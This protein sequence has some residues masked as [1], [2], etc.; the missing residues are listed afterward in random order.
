M[1]GAYLGPKFDSEAIRNY[2]DENDLPYKQ[3]D[4]KGLIKTVVGLLQEEK[5]AGWFQGRMEFGPRS[6]GARSI[7]GDPRSPN[8]QATP[9]APPASPAAG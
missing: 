8:M 3:Y 2:L 9:A 6:L 7:I 1:K 5:I 4:E